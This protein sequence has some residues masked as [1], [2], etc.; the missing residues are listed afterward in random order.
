M[1]IESSNRLNIEE[2]GVER[3]QAINDAMRE[4]AAERIEKRANG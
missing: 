4:M 1:A 3:R 2:P